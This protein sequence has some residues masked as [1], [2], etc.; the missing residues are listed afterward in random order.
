MLSLPKDAIVREYRR[1]FRESPPC[2]RRFLDG[3]VGHTSVLRRASLSFDY[4][5]H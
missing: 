3:V 5:C 2:H 1:L 4:I